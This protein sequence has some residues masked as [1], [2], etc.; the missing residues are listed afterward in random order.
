MLLNER[1]S[2]RLRWDAC[3]N[4]RDLGGC[5]TEDGAVTRFGAVVRADSLGRLTDRGCTA[6]EAYGIGAIIDLR[7][8]LEVRDAPSLFA[9]HATITM[10]HLPLDPGEQLVLKAVSAHEEMGLPYMAAVHA[11]FLATNQ[12]QIAA[13]MRTIATAPD[14]GVLIHCAAGRDRTGLIAALLLAVAKVPAP[15]V[16]ADYILS[17]STVAETMEATLS[18]LE[19]VYG[20]V[21]AYLRDAGVTEQE[22]A[23]LH[24]RLCDEYAI[25]DGATRG[26]G[27]SCQEGER[28]ARTMNDE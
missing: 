18:H 19:S 22:I 24:S 26:C 27:L 11:A 2:R 15:T 13:I 10:H 1:T 23:R 16:V 9:R 6:L 5:A 8:A 3:F 7:V 12:A 20:G 21:E 25:D 17:V 4:V 28:C 14:G